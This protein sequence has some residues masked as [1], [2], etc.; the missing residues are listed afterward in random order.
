MANN[1]FATYKNWLKYRETC[2][3]LNRLSNRELN[4]LGINRGEITQLA[5]RAAGY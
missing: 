1:L 3:E 2:N 4:D 5:K